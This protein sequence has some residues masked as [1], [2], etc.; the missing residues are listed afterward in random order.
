MSIDIEPALDCFWEA[1]Y[2]SQRVQS[3]L[4]TPYKLS[5][6]MMQGSSASTVSHN[7]SGVDSSAAAQEI[8]SSLWDDVFCDEVEFLEEVFHDRCFKYLTINESDCAVR[9]NR[10]KEY[11]LFNESW[12]FSSPE[13]K[14]KFVTNVL[15]LYKAYL[16]GG[17]GQPRL[18]KASCNLE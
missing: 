7:P 16:P 4:L 2:C 11:V 1:G 10:V 18:Q 14:H 8:D 15:L 12:G 9:L 17:E 13:K 3:G 6:A 5:P